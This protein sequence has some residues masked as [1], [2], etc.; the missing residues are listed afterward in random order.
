MSH[1]ISSIPANSPFL[2][3]DHAPK[4]RDFS[5]FLTRYREK[6]RELFR[7]QA[8]LDKLGLTRSLPGHLMEGIRSVDPLSV[9]I[10][11]EFGGR[12]GRIHEGLAVLAESAYESLSLGLTFGINWALFLQPVAKYGREEIKG[13][14]FR[15]ILRDKE[16]GGLMITEPDFGS[17]ALN[18][19]CSY[20]RRDGA[21]HLKGVKHWGG[22][23]GM[24]GFWLLTGREQADDG[25][26]RRD[27][28]FFLCD[29]SAPDQAI[30]VEEIYNTLGLY[31]IPYGRN[32]IDVRIPDTQRL[33]SPKTGVKMLLD[34]LHRS[35]LQFPGMGVGLIKRLLDEGLDHCKARHVGGRPLI[36]Y[37]QVQKR[38]A[39]IQA[40]FTACSALCAHSSGRAELG[41]DLSRSGLE[42]N[43]TKSVVTDLMQSAAQ[44]LLQLVGAKGYRLDHIAGR[45]VV[46]SRPFQIF[47]GS[48]DILYQQISESVLKLMRKVRE[49]NLL[50][51]MRGS[52]LSS[53]A[54]DYLA[55]LLD[56]E[57]DA[58]MPQR[59]L[60][61]LGRA[62]GRVLTME[63]VLELGDLGFRRDLI[64]NCLTT[65]QDEITSLLSTYRAGG[66]ARP[67]E[68]Y[69]AE[70]SWLTFVAPETAG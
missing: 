12:G 48:N 11:E 5:T 38:L 55:D 3:Q 22:L 51:F 37:D 15:R 39:R 40:S 16:M 58:G 19:R 24:A 44:S 9:Y 54:S 36:A 30:Q 41:D 42:A 49:R 43:A 29:V 69:E 63:R 64:A 23:T 4:D 57:F 25:T 52:E 10:P 62:L 61:E 35:R 18:M 28:D 68:D 8:D 32:R 56:F 21:Y 59:K 53:R 46:D 65:L 45:S 1:L 2:R 27:I 67:V 14:V 50:N 13:P 66:L 17:D 26:L 7:G 31:H 47:E 20:R 70:S 33:E 6:L 60:V 34:L